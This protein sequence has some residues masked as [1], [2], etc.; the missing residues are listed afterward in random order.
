MIAEGTILFGRYRAIRKYGEG[1][2]QSVYHAE[3][4]L[5]GR[6]V[7]LKVPL[8]GQKTT[9]FTQSAVLAGRVNH[10]SVAKTYDVF[11]DN[12]VPFLV[13]EF[14]DGPNFETLYPEG[15]CLD[16]HSGVRLMAGLA[17]G[18]SASHRVKVVHRD[19]KPSNVV[20][21]RGT[22]LSVAKITDFGIATLAEGVLEEA[23]A[24]GDITRSTSGTVKGALPYMAPEMMFRKAG[25]HPGPAADVWS[26][27]AM[28]FKLLT[29]RYPFGVGFEAA[30]NVK[31]GERVSW[32]AFMTA[33]AQFAPLAREL[34]TLVDSCLIHEP[35]RRPAADAVAKKCKE[36]CFDTAPRERGKVL[37]RAGSTGHIID[38]QGR[39]V[40]FHVDSFYGPIAPSPGLE[41]VFSSYPGSPYPRAHPIASIPTDA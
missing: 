12:G 20:L 3:D 13:E 8:L 19:L 38:S 10:A 28:M 17:S 7:A 33:K 22:L 34:Q 1:G 27:G 25:D 36:L 30:V 18:M 23:A 21:R 26:M 24:L 29:G 31:T 37:T 16:L 35:D 15:S 11:E 32:P 4:L 5:I 14:V 39:R 40:F 41:V 6:D 2:M 9:R